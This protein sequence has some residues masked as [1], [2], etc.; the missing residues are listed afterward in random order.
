MRKLSASLTTALA[1]TSLAACHG[2][3]S[4]AASKVASSE[5]TGDV[6]SSE[7]GSDAECTSTPY[8]SAGASQVSELHFT[9]TNTDPTGASPPPNVID[10]T[11][12]D[13]AKVRSIFGETNSLA[14]NGIGFESCPAGDAITYHLTFSGSNGTS[15]FDID[16]GGCGLVTANGAP[17]AQLYT[18]VGYW[19][20][21]A[22]VL[23]VSES[24]LDGP[25][26]PRN[27]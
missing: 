20:D 7:D 27:P 16:H 8:P 24:D 26:I 5:Q 21:L 15:T 23:G 9:T 14:C 18:D 25:L 19:R 17:F 6:D 1:L 4:E 22:T 10:I 3:G 13:V 11:V 2:G 12:S